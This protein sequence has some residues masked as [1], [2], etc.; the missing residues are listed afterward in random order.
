M[1]ESWSRGA[2]WILTRMEYPNYRG[3]EVV[4]PKYTNVVTDLIDI[5]VDLITMDLRITG[6]MS[7]VIISYKYRML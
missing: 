3:D 7:A 2:Q 1:A 5:S 6:I 4:L